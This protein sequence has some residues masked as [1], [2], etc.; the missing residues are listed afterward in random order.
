MIL[1]IFF[2]SKHFKC[3]KLQGKQENLGQAITEYLLL[4][5]FVVGFYLII[6]L[7]LKKLDLEFKLTLPIKAAFASAYRY[8]HTQAKG[9]DD[10]GPINHPRAEVVGENNFRIFYNPDIK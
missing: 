1:K 8:G 4:I 2:F 10:G 5:S 6:S 7:G 3:L 9:Y